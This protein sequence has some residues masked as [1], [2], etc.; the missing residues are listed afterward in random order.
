MSNMTEAAP[1]AVLGSIAAS[2][3]G[4]LI[5][6][7]KRGKNGNGNGNGHRESAEEL[8]DRVNR[9]LAVVERHNV[10]MPKNWREY[11]EWHWHHR[12]SAER[13]RH[14]VVERLIRAGEYSAAAALIEK[15]DK[16]DKDR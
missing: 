16:A 12:M 14:G 6:V 2:A 9:L 3:V 15:V 10:E 13:L 4:A 11:V 5:W 7:I 1:L 8:L